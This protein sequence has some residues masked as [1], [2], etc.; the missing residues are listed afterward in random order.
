ML[1]DKRRDAVSSWF[2]TQNLSGLLVVLITLSLC[3]SCA[4]TPRAARAV[5]KETVAQDVTKACNRIA[6]INM[7][8]F[9]DEPVNDPVYNELM[10]AGEK[11]VPCLIDKVTDTTPMRDPRMSPQRYSDLRV[12]DVAL[13]MLGHVAGLDFYKLLP[14][15]VQEKVKTDGVYAYFEFVEQPERRS[16]IQ[17]SLKE[18]YRQKYGESANP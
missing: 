17:K 14:A 12:G 2:K 6:E 15:H 18:W 1:S 3:L 5:A 9:K 4:S 11:A 7:L 10:A 8:P 16:D 13:F